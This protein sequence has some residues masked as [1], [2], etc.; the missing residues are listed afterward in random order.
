MRCLHAL[1][2]SKAQ[3]HGVDPPTPIQAHR[4]L[5]KDLKGKGW[6]DEIKAHRGTSKYLPQRELPCGERI[7]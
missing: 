6:R 7:V 3:W 1:L 4:P 5:S 2:A